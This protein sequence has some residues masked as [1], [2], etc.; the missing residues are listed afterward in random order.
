MDQGAVDFAAPRGQE[1]EKV[2]EKVSSKESLK[3]SSN[4]SLQMDLNSQPMSGPDV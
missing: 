3:A 4:A 2:S 1:F